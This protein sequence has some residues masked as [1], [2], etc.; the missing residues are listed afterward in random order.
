MKECKVCGQQVEDT[1]SVCD[2]CDCFTNKTN[3]SLGQTKILL[4]LVDDDW[5]KLKQLEI[6]IKNCFYSACPVDNDEIDKLM[7]MTPKNKWFTLL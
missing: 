1:I 6:Q 3:R 5:E 7:N 4:K 2:R